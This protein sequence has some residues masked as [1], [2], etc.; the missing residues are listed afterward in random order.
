MTTTAG[1]GNIVPYP[2][3]SLAD[4]RERRDAARKQVALGIDPRELKKE[5]K[6]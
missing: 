4:A 1:I 6:E 2:E 5:L 3:I